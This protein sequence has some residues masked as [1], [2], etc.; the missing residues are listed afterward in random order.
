MIVKKCFMPLLLVLSLALGCTLALNYSFDGRASA[1][2][3][4]TEAQKLAQDFQ[5]GKIDMATF[6][7]KVLELQS[8]AIEQYTTPEQR[9]M[10]E[11][12]QQQAPQLP[13]SVEEMEAAMVRGEESMAIAEEQMRWQQAHGHAAFDVTFPSALLGLDPKKKDER[14]TTKAWIDPL[15]FEAY[16]E[17]N[18]GWAIPI[19]DQD[20]ALI[21]SIDLAV[22]AVNPRW[23]SQHILD[24]FASAKAAAAEK[25]RKQ[26]S[27]VRTFSWGVGHRYVDEYERTF[28]KYEGWLAQNNVYFTLSIAGRVA[29]MSIGNM[30]SIADKA[31]AIA[32]QDCTWAALAPK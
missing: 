17:M 20:A 16:V 3:I 24:S 12:A 29:G 21:Y 15:R 14:L 25:F 19:P 31:A 1:A 32:G 18:I 13:K 10:L 30:D 23:S 4:E 7:K 28:G 6:Q 22:Q 9:R 26:G 5:S 11:Q 27:G 8:K 2:D